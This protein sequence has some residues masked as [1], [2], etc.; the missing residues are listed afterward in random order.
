MAVIVTTDWKLEEVARRTYGMCHVSWSPPFD[1]FDFE[2]G[3]TLP[4]PTNLRVAAQALAWALE[5]IENCTWLKP[6]QDVVALAT[7]HKILFEL[8]TDPTKVARWVN[9]GKWPKSY[10]HVKTLLTKCHTT[11]TKFGGPRENE[12]VFITL[13]YIEREEGDTSFVDLDA[14]RT[15]E[16]FDMEAMVKKGTPQA[17][18]E[19]RLQET[20]MNGVMFNKLMTSGARCYRPKSK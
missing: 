9:D 18:I 2:R 7:K 15:E 6:D 8:L 11:L 13:V 16:G 1:K 14:N 17:E 12:Q 10:T 19:K 5:S 3:F 20:R 4:Y